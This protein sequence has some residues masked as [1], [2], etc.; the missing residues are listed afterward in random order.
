LFIA[1]AAAVVVAVAVLPKKKDVK[2]VDFCPSSHT[3]KLLFQWPSDV[4]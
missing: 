3:K 1:A 4:E 2:F